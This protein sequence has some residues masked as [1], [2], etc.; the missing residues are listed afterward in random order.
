MIAWAYW[1]LPDN[2]DRPISSGAL[3][4]RPPWGLNRAFCGNAV[5]GT[6]DLRTRVLKGRKSYVLNQLVT[7]PEHQRRGASGMLLTWPVE[8]AAKEGIL[9]YLDTELDG[10][11]VKMYGKRGFVV[12]DR[13]HI[14][15]KN[16]GIDGDTYTHV[17]MIKEPATSGENEMGGKYV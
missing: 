13:L 2:K 15:L 14:D 7:L 3:P 5:N 11:V 4:G 12:V 1:I 10:E 6:E 8:R 17:A 9:C 16:C